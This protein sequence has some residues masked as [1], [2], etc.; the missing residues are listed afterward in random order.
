MLLADYPTNASLLCARHGESVQRRTRSTSSS[1]GTVLHLNLISHVFPHNNHHYRRPG[2]LLSALSL[3]LAFFLAL[4][5]RFVLL[6][7]DILRGGNPSADTRGVPH[8]QTAAAIVG[9][10][11]NAK[12]TL[13][14]TTQAL[15]AVKAMQ[16]AARAAANAGANNLGADPNHPGQQLP[17]VPNGLTNGGL[18]IAPGVGQ[19]PNLWTGAS[20]PT[21][22]VNGAKTNVTIVQNQQQAVLN[23]QTFNIGKNTHV[24]FDQTAG[25]A[26]ASQ[27]IAFNKVNDPSGVPS[28]ILGS[29]DALGQI[30]IINAN[31]IIFGG[32]SQIN[33]HALVASALPIN[34]NLIARGL[35]NNPD[36][37]FLFSALSMPAGVNGTP[38]FTPPTSNTP[39]G[40]YGDVVVQAGAQISAPTSADHVGGRVALV[41]ANV[42]NEGTISTPDGQTILAAGLQVGFAAH[43]TSDPTLRGLDTFVGAIVDLASPLAP[44]SGAATNGGL[45]DAPRA[46]VT[47]AGKN[48]DQ[49][50]FINSS[51]SVALNGRID[52]LADYNAVPFVN[53]QGLTNPPS[54]LFTSSG[55]VTLGPDSIT[56]ILPEFSSTDRVVGTQLALGSQVNIQGLA[57]HAASDSILLAPSADV[58]INAGTWVS[59]VSG[60]SQQSQFIAAGGQIYLDSGATI[61][62][63]G[64]QDVN[65]S[66]TENIVAAQLLGPEL[67]NSPLQRDGPLRGQTVYIDI[68]RTGTFNGKSWI[69]TPLADV[70]GYA[71]LVQRT[72][73]E[74]STN[75]GNVKLSA[76]ESVVLQ[77]GS[78]IDVSGGWINF[79]GAN[80]N[81]TQL[82]AGGHVFDIAQAT[83][84]RVYDGI[85]GNFNTVHSKWGIVETFT[86]PLGTNGHFQAGFTQGGNGGSLTITAPSMALDGNLVGHTTSGE[87]QQTAPP[88]ASKLAL[89][90]QAQDPTAPTFFVT[91]PTPPNIVFGSNNLAPADPFTLDSLGNPV[92]LR[93][94]RKQDVAL[95][96]DLVNADGFGNLS[97]D[98][99]DGNIT[100]PVDVDLTTTVGG[101][102]TLLGANIDI[103]GALASA[104]GTITLKVY[105]ISRATL[106]AL[107]L[108]PNRQTPPP[109]AT[110]GHFVL[111]ANASL[112]TAGM[113]TDLRSNA[114]TP[115]RSTY[116]PNGGK[117]DIESYDASLTS[118]SRIDVSGGV[119]VGA[120]SQINYG[121]A[122]AITIKSGQDLNIAS[123]LG[124]DLVLDSTLSGYSGGKGGSLNVFASFV[125]VGGTT[126]N[127]DALLLT[128]DF[129]NHGGFTNFT[130]A[131][132]GAP[133]NQTDVFVPAIV[134]AS[135]ATIRPVAQSLVA[136][137]DQ[138]GTLSLVPTLLPRG[139][140]NP[141]NLAF[142]ASGVKDPFNPSV[143]QFVRGDFVMNAGATIET[144]PLASVSISANTAAVLGS[145]I[146]PGGNISIAG[147]GNTAAL[148]SDQAHA[149]P[150]VDLG[151]SSLL[152]TAGTAVLIPNSLGLRTGSV[153]NGGNISVSGN[154]VAEKGATLDVSGA[155]AILDLDPGFSGRSAGGSLGGTQFVPTRVD[156]NG[157]TITLKGSQELF[158]DATLI[159]GGGGPGATG[160]TLSILSGRFLLP[161]QFSTPLDENIIVTQ[162]SL[163]IPPNFYPAGQTAIGH[164]VNNNIGEGHFAADAFNNSGFASLVLGGSIQFAGPV[165]LNAARS[166]VIGGGGVIRADAAVNLNAPYIA[167]GTAFRAPFA[168][169]ELTNAFTANEQPFFFSPTFGAGSL[170]ATGSLIDI[171]NLSL[172]NI[173]SLNIV[174]NN[175][176]VRGDGTLD[177]AGNIFITAG[178]IYPATATS[179]TIA[180]HNYLSGGSS[181]AGTVTINPSGVRPLPLSA[182]GQLNVYASIINDAGVLRAPLG[183]INLGYD[184]SGV[185]P[186]DQVSG[187]TFGVTQ[188]LNLLAGSVTSVS[189]VDPISGKGLTIP[190]GT[191]PTGTAWID[192][193]GNDITVSGVPNKSINIAAANVN[194]AARSTI[195]IR[196]GGDLFA[197]QFVSGT[198]G[199]IDILNTSSSFAVVPNYALGY[200]PYATFNSTTDSGYTNSNLQVGD[201][202]YLSGTNKLSAGTYTLLP[203][204]YALLPGA[205][206]VTPKNGTPVTATKQPDGSI[207][208]SGYRLNGFNA[209]SAPPIFSSFEVAS[210]SV[211]KQ[212]AEYNAY[213][214]NT[215]L[216]QSAIDHNVAVPRLPID[217]GHLLFDATQTMSILGTLQ[218]QAPNNGRG[219][220]VDISSPLDILIAGAGAAADPGVLVLDASALSAFGA[221]S[222]LIGG[223]RNGSNVT[224]TTNNLKI[225]NAGSPL[226]AP[227]LIFVANDNLIVAAYSD[228]EATGSLSNSTPLLLNGNGALLRVS[229]DASASIARTG[230]TAS[231][232]PRETIGAN[233]RFVGASVTLDSTYATS[234]DPTATISASAINLNSGQISIQ[235]PNGIVSQPTAGLVLAGEALQNLASADSLSLLSY[236]SIDIY[237]TGTIN[238]ANSLALHA[239]EIRGFN[240]GGVVDLVG[241]TITL[242]NSANGFA[243]GAVA[244]QNGR[245]Q[246]DAKTIQFG[247]NALNVDQFTNANFNASK[248][249]LLAGTGSFSMQGDLTI[250]APLITA[251]QTATQSISATG[252][253]NLESVAGST[254]P[255]SALA[256]RLTISGASVTDNIDIVLPSGGVTL[257]A[258][259]GDVIVGNTIDVGGTAQTFFDLTKYTSS[260][261][262]DLV[263]DQGSVNVNANT[264]INVA[265]QSGGGNG[266]TI[267]VSAPNGIFVADGALNGAGG[268]KG[269]DGSFELDVGN[270]ASLSSLD[271]ILNAAS[272]T[273]SRD[274]RVRT[275]DVLVDGV[276]NSHIFN[277][278]ADHGSI[279]VSGTIDAS[280]LTGGAI[281]LAA[282]GSVVLQSGSMLTVAAQNFDNAGKGGAIALAAGSEINGVI[283]S[284]A[285]LDIHA[286][287]TIDLSVAAAP[288]L[289]DFSGTLHLRAPQIASN[290]DLQLAPINGDIIGASKIVVE[291]YKLFDLTGS[292]ALSSSVQNSVRANA[293]TFVGAAG[294]TTPEY[295]AMMNRLFANNSGLEPVAIIEAGAEIINRTGNLT[296]GSTSST[297]SSDWDLSSYRFGPNGAPGTLTLR[298]AGNLVFFNA[299]SDGFNSSAYNATLLNAN[300][301]LPANEQS[302]SYHLTAGA[303]FGGADFHDMQSMSIL[304]ANSGSLLL[305]KNYGTNVF[306]PSGGSATTSNAVSTRFQV[307]RTGSGDIDIATG[308]DVKLLNQFATIYTAGTK[309]VDPTLG[310]TFDTPTPNF[311]GQSPFAPL[312]VAQQITPYA[313]QYSMAG[314]NVTIDAQGD[315]VHQTQIAG[316][317]VDDS[318]RE[319]PNNWLYR[320]A[321]VDPATGLFARV[322]RSGFNDVG[323]TTWWIDF[324]NFFEG[325]GALGG[326]NVSLTAGHDVRNVDAVAPTNARMPG[327][328]GNGNPIAPNA[329]NLVE[330][331]GGDVNVSAGN[332]IDGGVY[333]VER[334]AG[335]LTAGNA[336]K[337]N[338]TRS[339]SLTNI[340]SPSDV[341][342]EETWLPTT[343]F[344]G[345]ASF[346]VNAGGDL[347]LGPVSNPFLL[348]EGI[349]NSYWYKTYF[350]TYAATDAINAQS[351]T[352]NVTLRENITEG[353]GEYQ[354]LLQAWFNHISRFDVA[355]PAGS[356]AA[357]YQPWLRLDE[358][359]VG[360]YTTLAALLPPTLRVTAFAG[361]LNIEGNL[362]LFPAPTGT[363]D[364]VASGAINGLQRDGKLTNGNNAWDASR[365]NLSDADPN[366]VPGITT[367]FAYRNTLSNPS[368][369]GANI[370]T[371]TVF[372]NTISALFAETGSST[373][374][375]AVLQNKQAL[376]APGLL[377]A[378][379]VDPIHL[380]AGR[381]DISGLTL[382]S[383]KAARVVAGQDI[384]DIALYIQNVRADD[385]TLVAAGRDLIAYDPN[386]PL[387]VLANAVGNFA[388]GPAAGDIQISGPGTLEVLAGRNLDLGVGP[389]NADGTAVGITSIG[390]ARNPYLPFDGANIIAGAGIGISNGLAN[391][392]LD[393]AAFETQFLDPANASGQFARY[394]PELGKLLGLSGTNPAD[395]WTQFG[396]LPKEKQD[397]LALDIFYLV[398][399]DAGRDR[400]DPSS[401]SFGNF[402]QGFA[403]IAALFPESGNWRGDV[404][405]TSREIKTRN[406]GNIDIFAPG[407]QLT[408]GLTIGDNQPLD[409]GILT[410]HGGNISIFTHDNVNVGTS[411]IFTLRGGNEIIWSSAGDI[412]AGASS[413]TVQSA[414]PTRVLIDPQSGDVQT[415]L[416]GL[417]TGGGIGVL[418][419]V[420]GVP[421]SDVDL[422]APTGV[423]DAGDA[424]IRVSGNLNL[425][426]VQIINASNISVGGSSVGAPTAAAPNIG[427]LTSASNTAAATSNAAQQVAS[428]NAG[429]TQQEDVPSIISVEVLGYGGGEDEEERRRKKKQ[430]LEHQGSARDRSEHVASL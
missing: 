243:S 424:G 72:V 46:D 378:N 288:S 181:H 82:V 299:L 76:G 228:I 35:L 173:G 311:A 170:N 57:V 135:D 34:D 200:A 7:G 420:A 359:N 340:T 143:Q 411:R 212:R 430:Q 244:G 213:S 89:N 322:T 30:Y 131:G 114:A 257:H 404:S 11:P 220:L 154:I 55:V 160:G 333:Y 92:A 21:Q 201:Q 172:Q 267:S 38:A 137:L 31:G 37:Q 355:Q 10:A 24:L 47:I 349:N 8:G 15:N 368:A 362:T 337:T 157:G 249:V 88:N 26:N 247:A 373:G 68:T 308:R 182:G 372:L 274:I 309:V 150:T 178:Q 19:N 224:V 264:T 102:I 163:T 6:A 59:Y 409:Q 85:L 66:V 398:L 414:P 423:I 18:Q 394:L 45:I 148:F 215:Y 354:P 62:V 319:L 144:D 217:S 132:L 129:F 12:D 347:L 61:D 383:G 81:T 187:Q 318:S 188:Q 80:V 417:A 65:A 325:V 248:S 278:S 218:S 54:F 253:V 351:L 133:T 147:G 32:S 290:T 79:A 343:L 84:D 260:G 306:T 91:S 190:Y 304:A 161:G 305:G 192:P 307:I 395:I 315:I 42:D 156:S 39:D 416:A 120:N 384:T 123:V 51:T 9:G 36:N 113:I 169:D 60:G 227:D 252:A 296:L 283:D 225:D 101:S 184:G 400:N 425:A 313:A 348:P 13:A 4:P 418:E 151:P 426:A 139:V 353:L 261:Y 399:R 109:D 195:D 111:G 50:G 238:A 328:N 78:T 149:L 285:L 94:D 48:V 295:T 64:S 207:I 338:A 265:A 369:Q 345:K 293:T 397:A 294:T 403:A 231:N 335:T 17:N 198:G 197:Y 332:N 314:G 312:G 99:R 110:R 58:S 232:I 367:P 427:S 336:V 98:N 29:L 428:Q 266:G 222:L 317:L 219:G 203:A 329:N 125:Q 387:R 164:L 371:T 256:A 255:E 70:S 208:V 43:A 346:D 366:S 419:T 263:A 205:F 67:A 286:G 390:N 251:T 254:P 269:H 127:P 352:G 302:W 386:S 53:T 75:G 327:K 245:L 326:G 406:G 90:F 412:A 233:A 235:L 14:Q 155:S 171:G 142:V 152:S 270:L 289:G 117:I 74:L 284:S 189:A 271:A 159:G 162:N 282:S 364:L 229:A 324:S 116:T 342:A 166:L 405:L 262:V 422:I 226:T 310:G 145:I 118:G 221:E 33:L 214:A 292:G 223:S 136:T 210:Q 389:N 281:N 242:D 103:E 365:L 360:A 25:G 375:A 196:G 27:W 206:L 209:P 280:G 391:S 28:Q 279:N 83:P 77:Q 376:H 234:L 344:A 3:F 358:T 236:S 174:A 179:F 239:A 105:D 259:S 356:S 401:P 108:D 44:Y 382:F 52:L 153:L 357:Y 22:T 177:V 16:A 124:G 429:P 330:L 158:T 211:I 241:N 93:S 49:L 298:A 421:P 276:A 396:Q 381:G 185:A 415:D 272:F 275:G 107:S 380:Y 180:A 71:N 112:S 41:G 183:T 134:I 413:K 23:W 193:A 320:R 167:L 122:G 407:G 334:G 410:E 277:V 115:A 388:S 175:G 268:A 316:Q 40:H 303:D 370:A 106:N 63:A 374:A 297:A 361:D 339:V 379:D 176:A 258:T 408:V 204:R 385:I 321:L 97:I 168:A 165:T 237:G 273:Q 250:S 191:N 69:G 100:V 128:P 146:A 121:S 202:I 73:G 1:R 95:S 291:G 56:Q 331:G 392:N 230:V 126:T 20:L 140:R 300:S 86:N 87:R 186:V 96:P 194:D 216:R 393:F 138:N 2:P 287:S 301:Q 323:S 402:D 199:T 5:P 119:T 240:N 104:G 363:V 141:V 246:L 377:H 341:L 130:I 350:S